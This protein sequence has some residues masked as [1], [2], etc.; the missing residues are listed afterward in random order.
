[1]ELL[2]DLWIGR[3]TAL[4]TIRMEENGVGGNDPATMSQ[5][6]RNSCLACQRCMLNRASPGRH[7]YLQARATMRRRG[8][9][10][11]LPLCLLDGN[12]HLFQGIHCTLQAAAA[13]APAGRE[14][15]QK[16]G[17]M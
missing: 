7:R 1:M 13:G 2:E 6:G 17:P 8:N 15:L 4:Y 12:A 5:H 9:V 10:V 11:S 14:Q 16:I 3:V